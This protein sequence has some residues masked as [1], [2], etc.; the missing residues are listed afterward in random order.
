MMKERSLRLGVVGL[1]RAFSLM[2][3]TL[4]QDERIE[5]VAACDPREPARAQFARD[6]QQPVYP[7]IDALVADPR[8]EAVYIASPHEFHA[9]HTRMAAAGGKHV[10]V[11]KPMA[12]TMAECDTMIEACRTRPW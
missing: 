3:P 7:S 8:V 2:L 9:E 5:L 10:L 11:E 1:G 12:L 4:V 6:F